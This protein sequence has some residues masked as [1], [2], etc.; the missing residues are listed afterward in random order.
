MRIYQR[1]HP[2]PNLF[3]LNV[4]YRGNLERGGN[5]IEPDKYSKKHDAYLLLRLLV[6]FIE[7][8]V[9]FRKLLV[10]WTNMALTLYL[11][12]FIIHI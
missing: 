8:F 3:G 12:I 7:K 4:F 2:S 11:D 1:E 9:H 5:G 6:L 10:R